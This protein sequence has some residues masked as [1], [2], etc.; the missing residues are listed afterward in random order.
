MRALPLTALNMPLCALGGGIL[1]INLAI[2]ARLGLLT[3][4]VVAKDGEFYIVPQSPKGKAKGLAI[5]S[6][7]ITVS[8]AALHLIS[9]TFGMGVSL[10]ITIAATGI[11][12][13]QLETRIP[14]KPSELIGALFLGAIAGRLGTALL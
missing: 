7:I 9:L 12:L 13:R 3:Q 11:L 2:Q 5:L 10:G 6:V 1:G 4:I 14:S 8:A